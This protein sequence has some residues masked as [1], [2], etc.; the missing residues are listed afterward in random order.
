MA[1]TAGA[2]DNNRELEP[3]LGVTNFKDLYGQTPMKIHR[4]IM[5]PGLLVTQLASQMSFAA[6]TSA[7]CSDTIGTFYVTSGALYIRPTAG[8]A[9]LTNCT[10][11][12]GGY[13]TI[14]KTDPNYSSYYAL[15][16]AADLAGQSIA[17]RTT[18]SSSPCTVSY[19]TLP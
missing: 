2:V 5:W 16:L 18:D 3:V 19:I 1:S 6:C 14:P 8:L 9:G 15:L 13:V 10:P 17:M 7:S 4:G 12:S 11:L